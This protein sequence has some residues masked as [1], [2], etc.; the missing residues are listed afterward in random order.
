MLT[1]LRVCHTSRKTHF[2]EALRLH[3]LLDLSYLFE[4]IEITPI[5]H[6]TQLNVFCFFSSSHKIG[7]VT[8]DCFLIVA[9]HAN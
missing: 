5:F 7:F 2:P 4:T 3:R 8:F 1:L 6:S 9:V